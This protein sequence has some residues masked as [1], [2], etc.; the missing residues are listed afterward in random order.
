M[1]AA[2][3]RSEYVEQ[4]LADSLLE[5]PSIRNRYR[6]N[7]RFQETERHVRL[8]GGG[9]GMLVNLVPVLHVRRLRNYRFEKV[10]LGSLLHVCLHVACGMGRDDVDHRDL[11]RILGRWAAVAADNAQGDRRGALI[12][13]VSTR[14]HRERI[15][16][17][18]CGFLPILGALAGYLI[19][20]HE[21]Q[22]CYRISRSYF[23]S[24]A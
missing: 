19:H 17:L 4:I 6:I 3:T 18:L 1:V 9:V 20:A 2:V 22:R 14:L 7:P 16:M 12:T 10:F 15:A 23:E 21:G 5:L 11:E 24:G 8:I 13:A